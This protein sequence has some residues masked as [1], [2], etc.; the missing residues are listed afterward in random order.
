MSM[1]PTHVFL[2][3]SAVFLISSFITLFIQKA[4]VSPL[5]VYIIG[6]V[7]AAVLFVLCILSLVYNVPLSRMPDIVLSYFK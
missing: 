6:I 1:F 5:S 2:V 3:L 4:K 7:V